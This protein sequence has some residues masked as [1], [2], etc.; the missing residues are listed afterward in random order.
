MSELYL[1][2]FLPIDKAYSDLPEELTC[3]DYFTE[4]CKVYDGKLYQQ[5]DYDY[6]NGHPFKIVHMSRRAMLYD[7]PEVLK[8]NVDGSRTKKPA[9]LYWM[10]LNNTSISVVLRVVTTQFTPIISVHRFLGTGW[11]NMD[12]DVYEPVLMFNTEDNT[13]GPFLIEVSSVED[14]P[15]GDF[16]W[17][18]KL[19]VKCHTFCN[20][21]ISSNNSKVI[22]GTIQKV[23]PFTMIGIEGQS[24][25]DTMLKQSV[26]QTYAGYW[27]KG[28]RY[29][30]V[31]SETNDPYDGLYDKLFIFPTMDLLY[32]K[33]LE[34]P[35]LFLDNFIKPPENLCDIPIKFDPNGG[36]KI[37][38]DPPYDW[39]K[40]DRTIRICD[41][42]TKVVSNDGKTVTF[43]VY[44]KTPKKDMVYVFVPVL[45]TEFMI[46]GSLGYDKWIKTGISAKLYTKNGTLLTSSD[47]GTTHKSY[48]STDVINPAVDLTKPGY[49]DVNR[50]HHASYTAVA[51]SNNFE[52][53]A[54]VKYEY[55][56]EGEPL[57]CT[58][59]CYMLCYR[60][61]CGESAFVANPSWDYEPYGGYVQYDRFGARY[62][63]YHIRDNILDGNC[64]ARFYGYLMHCIEHDIVSL[65]PGCA[66]YVP[67]DRP[68]SNIGI[69]PKTDSYGYYLN[70]VAKCTQDLDHVCNYNETTEPRSYWYVTDPTYLVVK[71]GALHWSFN[72]DVQ[73]T[74][75][76]NPN[77]SSVTV[78]DS[79]T[80]K[81]DCATLPE[82]LVYVSYPLILNYTNIRVPIQHFLKEDVILDNVFDAMSYYSHY[83]I[84]PVSGMGGEIDYSTVWEF[85]VPNVYDDKY[86]D[87]FSDP[88]YPQ[89]YWNMTR[90]TNPANRWNVYNHYSKRVISFFNGYPNSL[91]RFKVIGSRQCIYNTWGGESYKIY[92]EASHVC[93]NA[94]CSEFV[95]LGWVDCSKD[96]LW[97]YA[98]CPM[99]IKPGTLGWWNARQVCNLHFRGDYINCPSMVYWGVTQQLY[100]TDSKLFKIMA[101]NRLVDR[102]YPLQTLDPNHYAPL[103]SVIVGEATKAKR[104]AEFNDDRWVMQKH[105][106]LVYTTGGK[107]RDDAELVWREEKSGKTIPLQEF[108]EVEYT[109]NRY[110]AVYSG[111]LE[112][113]IDNKRYSLWFKKI[114]REDNEHK[115]L[116]TGVYMI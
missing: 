26:G 47:N 83:R 92:G 89:N 98:F 66:L 116:L 113:Y 93:T 61:N 64:A 103:S 9:K 79:D 35:A 11:T 17:D 5:T 110:F 107:F 114:E 56:G 80:W 52:G 33:W 31:A 74:P 54:E 2:T 21:I 108:K 42:D 28:W 68:T 97:M 104:P 55:I 101:T 6:L 71:R 32:K 34:Y 39:L 86:R 94:D 82:S 112:K 51:L 27:F 15:S 7:E 60:W 12:N 16:E 96:I 58:I 43:K 25:T 115:K 106:I 40:P 57:D 109:N 84:E 36:Y 63:G 23:R 30:H 37:T 45:T 18:F 13:I 100:K 41:A 69:V 72:P 44:I 102:Y 19:L 90:Y 99:M 46:V 95:E 48:L 88:K 29:P 22:D 14:Q 59:Y 78:S 81:N 65:A 53:Y 10:M 91:I 67:V 1:S 111:P 73:A 38:Y 4:R 50:S 105:S 70:P 24:L 49:D 62:D 76:E 87:Q 8:G 75:M 77:R 85:S 3:Q 20:I